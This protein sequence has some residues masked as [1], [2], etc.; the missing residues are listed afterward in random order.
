MQGNDSRHLSKMRECDAAKV[1]CM[2]SGDNNCGV[3]LIS[4]KRQRRTE[5]KRSQHSKNETTASTVTMR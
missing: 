3:V 1:P 4:R 5:W 2:L